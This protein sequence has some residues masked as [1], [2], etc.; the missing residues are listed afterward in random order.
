MY[1]HDNDY[2]EYDAKVEHR[3][4]VH[5]EFI[6]EAF[7]SLCNRRRVEAMRRFLGSSYARA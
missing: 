1:G 5:A 3:I 6:A 2:W 4:K 7:E